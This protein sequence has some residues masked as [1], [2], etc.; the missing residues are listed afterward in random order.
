MIGDPI[1]RLDGPAKVTGKATYSAEWPLEHLAYGVIVQSTVANGEIT[2]IDTGEASALPG[3]VLVMTPENAPRLPAEGRGGVNPPSGR[4]LTLLQNRDIRY[5]GQPVALVVADTFEQATIAASLVK[6]SY[7]HAPAAVEMQAALDTATPVTEKL[8]G[9]ADPSSR[10]GDVDGALAASD[11]TVD[12]VYTTPLETHNAMEPHA[13]IA[14]WDG[15]RLTLHDATQYVFGVKRSAAKTFGIPEENVRVISQFVGGAFGSKGSAW[16]HVMLAA[17]AARAVKRPVKLVLSRKQMFGPVGARPY[18]VQHLTIGAKRDGAIT[19]IRQDVISSTSTLE[20][21]VETST[22]Q[23][24]MLYDVANVETAQRLVRLNIGT[25]TF[26]RGPGESSGTFGLESAMD[27]LAYKLAIDPIELRLKNYAEKDPDTGQPFSS[28]SLRECYRQG[29][30]RIGWHRRTPAPRSMREG[31]LLVGIGMAT[32]TYPAKRQPAQALARLMPDGTIVVQA[33]TH[34]FGTGTYT[35]M[36]QVA[37]DALGVP[38]ERIRF[39]L[40][41]T[42]YPENPISAGSMTASSTGSAVHAAALAL[43]ERFAQLGVDPGDETAS[44]TLAGR[45]SEPIEGRAQVKPGPERAQYSMHAFG[46]VF[47][48]VRV[49][50]GL[51]EVRI[52]R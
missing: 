24:R 6:V 25:P 14:Q 48:D 22:L 52:A 41:D 23:T 45:A 8:V 35:S 34:E 28:K 47:A 21:W 29:A 11:V 4:V 7:R 19:A 5:N 10:R 40:G 32:A 42:A 38:V 43:K 9:N 33:A 17:M 46:A 1:D 13:T 49:D 31:D 30:E 50:P 2:A 20:D 15:D 3:V 44:R 39:E 37:A 26:N 36:S 12:E 27:E 18:T 16:S 51:G